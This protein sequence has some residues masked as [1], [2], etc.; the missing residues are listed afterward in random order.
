M[1]PRNRVT[2]YDICIAKCICD[3]MRNCHVEGRERLYYVNIKLV[4]FFILCAI[5]DSGLNGRIFLK[6][7]K[8]LSI[9]GRTDAQSA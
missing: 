5:Y 7:L 2:I 3:W 6:Y 4:E 1:K 9:F 8:F